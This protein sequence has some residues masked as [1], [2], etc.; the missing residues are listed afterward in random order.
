[1][2]VVVTHRQ[3]AKD[4]TFHGVTMKAGDE[5]HMPI[6][7]ANR[8]PA[9]FDNPHMVDI[10]RQPRHIT[11]GTGTHN[12]IGIHL[13]KRELRI[14]LEEFLKRFRNIRLAEGQDYAYHTGRTFGLEKL[15]LVWDRIAEDRA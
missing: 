10:D 13:A 8:D 14:V 7:L 11:F 9:M 2:S 4:F 15:P 12:C 5:V 6:S 1:F 3:V